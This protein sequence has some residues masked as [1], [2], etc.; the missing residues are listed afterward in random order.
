LKRLRLALLA[1]LAGTAACELG[2]RVYARLTHRERGLVYDSELGWRMVPGVEKV[3]R[4]WS[5]SHPARINS[6]GWRDEEA[7]YENTSGKRRMVVVGDSFTFG[8]GVDA[9]E[10]FTE[11]LETLVPE[12]EV[13]NLGMNAIGPDQEVLVLEKEGL[14]YG[15]EL[16]LCQVFEGNDFAD[17][18]YVRNGYLP[19][20]WF[21]MEGGEL[22]EVPPV[23]TW[24]VVLRECGYLGELAYRLVQRRTPYRVEA[25][26]WLERDTTPL[27]EK[28]LL[29]MNASAARVGARFLVLLVRVR[30]KERRVDAVLPAL[31]AAGIPVI[32]TGPRIEDAP[33]R[34]RYYLPDGHWSAAGHGVV[35]AMVAERLR[36]MGL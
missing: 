10:R 9:G 27:V 35:A 34:G 36:E 16:V 3:G 12:L 15:P 25:E 4:F 30:G 22:V 20:P 2:L 23:R 6:H 28:L 31:G 13:I 8:V 7:A 1:L 29:R 14:R 33:E 19:K 5:G 17:V 24:D 11:A 32:D 21:R 26:E 18:G